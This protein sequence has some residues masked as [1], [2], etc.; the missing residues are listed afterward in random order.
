[1]TVSWQESYHKPRQ[2]VKIRHYSSDKGLYSQD[3]GPYGC[4]SR[5]LKKAENRIIDV[6]KL[7][8]W[9][10]LLSP[11]DSKEIKPVNLKGYQPRILIG[12][13]V[14]L[15]LKLNL[16]YFSHLMQIADSLKKSP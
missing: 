6:F 14:I 10:R 13:T 8:C 5:T 16:Q 4:E 9:K 11:L 1:M 2:C 3:K 15:M 12:R 7:Q